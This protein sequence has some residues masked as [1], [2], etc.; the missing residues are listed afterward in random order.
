MLANM[1]MPDWTFAI[2][3]KNDGLP[4]TVAASHPYTVYKTMDQ[5]AC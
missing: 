3:D 1:L 2:V 4:A 5:G